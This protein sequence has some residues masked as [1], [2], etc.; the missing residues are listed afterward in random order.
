MSNFLE[1]LSIL[2]ISAGLCYTFGAMVANELALWIFLAV[3]IMSVLLAA[4]LIAHRC[5]TPLS[6]VCAMQ[7]DFHAAVQKP[8]LAL[9]LRGLKSPLKELAEELLRNPGVFGPDFKE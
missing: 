3:G 6:E 1:M 9:L 8:A 7:A 5:S 4:V 2:V